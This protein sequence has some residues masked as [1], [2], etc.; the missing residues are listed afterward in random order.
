[1]ANEIA[2]ERH[3]QSVVLVFN[4]P[5]A[6]NAFN[7]E[8]ANQF[9]PQLKA[10]TTSPGTRAVAL[11]GAG[12]NFMDGLDLTMFN[13]DFNN[14]LANANLLMQAYHNAIREIN[15]MDKPVLSAVEGHVA[16][17]G[18]SFMLASD[19]VIA[20]RSTVFQTR[21]A[22]YGMS[23]DGGASFHL[24][25]KAGSA[26]AM[27]LFLLN[28]PFSAEQ[29]LQYGLINLVVDDDKLVETMQSWITKL[30]NGPT[31]AF[32]GAKRVV[33]KAFEQ[34]LNTHLSLEHTYWGATSRSFDFKDA[35]RALQA[36]RDPKFSGA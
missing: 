21:F 12:G 25:R 32:G 16:G 4:R 17:P 9:F 3:G 28:E 34:D 10:L 5:A 29:A 7:L 19:L 14:T 15:V 33:A 20:A 11:R 23:P 6:G 24:A 26:K 13:G 2:I 18:L 22:S 36:K 31:K 1:M 30:A 35:L 8:M 27:E